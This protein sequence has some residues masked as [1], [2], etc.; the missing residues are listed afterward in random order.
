MREMTTGSAPLPS[1]SPDAPEGD[2]S[3][4]DISSRKAAIR[5]PA[6]ARRDALAPEARLLASQS[7]PERGVAA[8]ASLG[9]A[10][11]S[12]ITVSGFWPIRSELDPRPL[13]RAIADGGA[14]LA[15][16]CVEA[17]VLVFRRF[18]FG[19]RLA[20]AGFGLSQPAVDAKLVDPHL[21]L[22]PLA[23][24]DR[25]GG[26]IGYGKGYYDGAISRLV[27]Q[28]RRPRTLGLAFACQETDSVPLEAH[29]QRLDAILTEEQLILA[30]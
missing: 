1:R 7:L 29:D 12:A 14:S 17:G 15:L 6:L 18:A 30:S 3:P 24:F 23:A 5:T 2:R 22:V 20:Q 10:E 25:R 27:A 9:V 28:G 8:L 21:M 4:A 13:M 16:P 19:Q 11:M 26:R